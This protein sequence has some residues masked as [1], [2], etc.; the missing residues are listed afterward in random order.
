M[1]NK[2]GRRYDWVEYE[3]NTI[4]GNKP[5][6]GQC[7]SKKNVDISKILDTIIFLLFP[8][9]DKIKV[10]SWWRWLVWHCSYCVCKCDSGPGPNTDR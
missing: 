2:P 1:S 3:D 5:S 10:D 6:N 7:I 9:A 4:L 8:H